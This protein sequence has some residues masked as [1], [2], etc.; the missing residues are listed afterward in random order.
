MHTAKTSQ[1]AASCK[2]SGF[3]F[4][5][6][7]TGSVIIPFFPAEFTFFP[8]LVSTLFALTA[9]GFVFFPLLLFVLLFAVVFFF[10]VFEA[11]FISPLLISLPENSPLSYHF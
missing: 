9:A 7:G 5:F 2:I 4:S 6:S 10:V 11:N 8:L 1:S 3:V